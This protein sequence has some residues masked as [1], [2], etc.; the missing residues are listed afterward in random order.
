MPLDDVQVLHTATRIKLNLYGNSPLYLGL[1]SEWRV[2]RWRYEENFGRL[3]FVRGLAKAGTGEEYKQQCQAKTH[4]SSKV[5]NF[6]ST[7]NLGDQRAFAAA[8]FALRFARKNDDTP[9]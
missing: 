7:R 9:K 5:E 1:S 2:L 6:T 4:E 3:C 8:R